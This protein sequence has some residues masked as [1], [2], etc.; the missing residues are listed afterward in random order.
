VP[1]I[2]MINARGDTL[3]AAELGA[4]EL[5]LRRGYGPQ[6]GTVTD[7]RALFTGQPASPPPLE[8]PPVATSIVVDTQTGT[9]DTAKMQAAID[10]AS[11]AVAA[12]N[13]PVEVRLSGRTYLW[14]VSIP[15]LPCNLTGKLRIN[16]GGAKIQL[17]TTAATL[18]QINKGADYDV[19]RNV[20][21]TDLDIDA[22][23]VAGYGHVIIGTATYSTS[24]ITTHMRLGVD[25]I[26]VRRVRVT[27]LPTNWA[28]TDFR[29][30]I[31]L[32]AGLT[33]AAGENPVSV[34]NVTVEDVRVE[35]GRFGVAIGARFTTSGRVYVDDCHITRCYHDTGA[36]PAAFL[37]CT[38]FFL[39][40]RAYGGFG[41]ITHCHGKNSGDDGVEINGL[42]NVLIDDCLI[43][44]AANVAY[45]HNNFSAPRYGRSQK[46]KFRECHARVVNL[47]T[48]ATLLGRGFLLNTRTVPSAAAADT[49]A[50]STTL[51]LADA[52]PNATD[53]DIFFPTRGTVVA[54]TQVLTY[55]GLTGDTLTGVTGITA[56]IATGTAVTL[57]NDVQNVSL[58]G[59]SLYK[60]GQTYWEYTGD[61]VKVSGPVRH[62][63]IREFDYTCLGWA[64]NISAP[65]VP[66]AFYINATPSEAGVDT[67]IRLD[68]IRLRL[69][70][71]R[72]GGS[73]ADWIA[74]DISGTAPFVT[75]TGIEVDNAMTGMSAVN[76]VE[77]F[78]F[79]RVTNGDYSVF[80]KGLKVKALGDVGAV[81]KGIH[82][83]VQ[84]AMGNNPL[85]DFSGL[86]FAGL[87]TGAQDVVSDSGG[88]VKYRT[89]VENIITKAG[90]RAAAANIAPTTGTYQFQNNQMRRGVVV[91]QGGTVT[92]IQL[93]PS[94]G[95]LYTTGQTSGTFFLNPGDVLQVTNSVVPTMT[96][97][98]FQ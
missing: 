59:C 95:A 65:A 83:G 32:M 78:R 46:I 22:N 92:Q 25:N 93:G 47:A 87:L 77:A 31:Y 58:E 20:E 61:A 27:N 15:R 74:F 19:F 13:G 67:M 56:P 94:L 63:T 68:N 6:T 72:T 91:V 40:A 70:G 26:V 49:A 45:L 55:T 82:T 90:G 28:G 88:F 2:P 48:S 96:F 4:F 37:G 79:G 9:T 66:V 73:T 89:F 75:A 7:A 42:E 10:A 8:A 86:D 62:L 34:T 14:S 80:I 97:I 53:T 21:I 36:T 57:I 1:S 98:P 16:G 5:L 17:S 69:T 76:N 38:N 64:A 29:A 54:G 81:Q 84:G 43:E 12:G 71:A 11:A 85:L 33:G 60:Q 44:D 23:N 18:L 35:G 30:G 24:A 52:T 50:A 39:G 51:P 3:T 41:S